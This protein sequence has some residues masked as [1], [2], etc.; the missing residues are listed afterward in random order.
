M[1]RRHGPVMAP[2]FAM[3]RES[4]S[5]SFTP[6]CHLPRPFSSLPWCVHILVQACVRARRACVRFKLRGD[7]DLEADAG[8]LRVDVGLG[9]V[10]RRAGRGQE[11]RAGDRKPVPG[12]AMASSLGPLRAKDRR[13]T[14]SEVG[15]AAS[16]GMAGG[17]EKTAEE[18]AVL[19]STKP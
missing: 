5:P 19:E 15:E 13:C 16:R 1:L 9:R 7:S 10:D 3:P 2:V 6:T 11:A 8:A 17:G 14:P 12:T 18:T 4:M